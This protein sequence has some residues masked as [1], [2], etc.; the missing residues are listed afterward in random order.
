MAS[1]FDQIAVRAEPYLAPIP[2]S[3]PAGSPAR[4]DVE[5]QAVAA[6]VMKLE[7]PTGESVDW[8]R[9][10]RG[11]TGLLR[12]RT[13]DLVLSAYLAHALHVTE[14]IDGLV[15]GTA[16]LAGLLDRYWE[17]MQ[18]DVARMR[19]RANAISWFLER[20]IPALE[21]RPEGSASAAQADAL[22]AAAARLAELSQA[23]LGSATPAFQGF[24]SAAAR[25]RP[26]ATG[27]IP[28][29]R[30]AVP[31]AQPAESLP[32]PTATP[33]LPSPGG[34]DRETLEKVGSMLVDLA[35]RIREATPT[36]P[37]AFRVARVGMWLH[38]ESAPVATA[39]RSTIP[40]P[41]PSLLSRL[42]LLEQ[43]RQWSALLD[44]AES[45]QA[46]HRFALDLQ[47][48]SWT[49]LQGL[50]AEFDRARSAVASELRGLLTRMP[51]LPGLA[52]SDGSPLADPRTSSWIDGVIL[53][54][55]APVRV[56]RDDAGPVAP[57]LAEL[58]TNLAEGRIAEGLA[59]AQAALLQLPSGRRQFLARLDV[60]RACSAAGLGHLA[61]GAYQGLDA[62][63]RAHGL[64]SWE[65]ELAVSTL[66]GLIATLRE[67][68]KDSRGASTQLDECFRR[69]CILDPAAAYEVRP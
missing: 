20:A 3:A 58:G 28:A 60:A 1:T 46:R 66:K 52:F 21:A 24:L 2:G 61:L 4:L 18:P 64:E 6:E 15:T 30:D 35:G 43:N 10:E 5:Y 36:D 63:V 33:A 16:L 19:G 7:A 42:A 47:R 13:K 53:A 40:P 48:L 11:A 41:P 14:G 9:V 55:P 62:E 49:A 22:E 45:A 17:T 51:S 31:A 54:R 56:A 68:M 69:L 50:G 67:I 8:K 39:G 44:E 34:D 25:L 32:R 29:P 23:R 57:A 26:A 37:T 59:A 65:P 27:E 38:L 12:D